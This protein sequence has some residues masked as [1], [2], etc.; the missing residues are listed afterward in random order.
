MQ[1]TQAD[2]VKVKNFIDSNS[3]KQSNATWL[4]KE[5]TSTELYIGDSHIKRVDELWTVSHS[6]LLCDLTFFSKRNAMYAAFLIVYNRKDL[7]NSLGDIDKRIDIS[8]NEVIRF[9]HLLKMSR[10]KHDGWKIELFH[11]KLSESIAKYK[12]AKDE[13]HDWINYAKYINN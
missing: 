1:L 3:K 13:L 4:V 5:I 6:T 9:K 11:N 7:I 8:Q 2:F 12:K 10:E